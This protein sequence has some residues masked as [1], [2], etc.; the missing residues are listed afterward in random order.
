M[1][2]LWEM[3][4]Q[5]LETELLA[6]LGPNG[7][8]TFHAVV[9]IVN[10]DMLTFEKA[11]L[12]D[13]FPLAL[14]RSLEP[15]EKF[16]EHGTLFV[17]GKLAIQHAYPYRLI[18]MVMIEGKAECRVAAQE[19]R[20]RVLAFLAKRRALG[21]LTAADGETVSQVVLDHTDLTLYGRNDSPDATFYGITETFFTIHTKG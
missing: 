13:R 4:D 12:A 20:R 10:D 16:G 9:S 11:I 6:E 7:L 5:Y 1:A 3:I 15:T 17:T 8:Y 14:L 18:T 19:M 21:G 2:S